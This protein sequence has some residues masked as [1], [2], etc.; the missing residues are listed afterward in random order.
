MGKEK[1][2][3]LKKFRV[4]LVQERELGDR[5]VEAETAAEA[6]KK[7]YLLFDKMDRDAEGTRLDTR[8]C[9]EDEEE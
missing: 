5:V 6:E 2:K 3:K 9:D 4:Y 7:A 8:E 1:N